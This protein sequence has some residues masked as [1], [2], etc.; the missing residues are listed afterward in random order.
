VVNVVSSITTRRMKAVDENAKYLGVLPL[1]LMEN[2]GKGVVNALK[3]E[4]DIKN[5]KITVVCGLG[6]NGGDGFVVARHLAALGAQVTVILIGS[7]ENIKTEEARTNWNALENMVFTVKRVVL[8]D[9]SEISKIKELITGSDIVVDA[10]FGTGVKG[11]IKEPF[12]TI[13]DLINE[14]NAF[15]VSVDTPS[16]LNPD[17]GEIHDK[18]VK[19]N[20][21]VTFH[22]A[23][24]GLINGAAFTGKL[25]VADIGIP[26]EAE[27]IVGPGDI[28]AAIKNRDI[29]SHKGDFGKILVISGG[30]EYHGAPVF[31]ALSALRTGADLV[32]LTVPSSVADVVRSFSPNLIVRTLPGDVLCEDA[33]GIIDP[34]INWATSIAIGPGLGLKSET[35][36]TVLTIL[37]KAR[38]KSKPLLVDADAIKI[39][40]K[41]N[42]LLKETPTLVTPHPGEF[43]ILTG[44]KLPP[45]ENIEER[46][47]IVKECAGKLGITILLKGAED[48]IS[49][50][51][52]YRV[53]LTGNPGMTVG[54]TGDV[55][56][57]IAAV[58]LAWGNSP[59]D[60][61][62]AA[63]F[64]N[65]RA[66]DIAVEK[67]G[68]HITATDVIEM[69]PHAINEIIGKPII[70]KKL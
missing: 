58:L 22:K 1:M 53:N 27:I 8:K 64:I 59:L 57:G 43:E 42:T 36:E 4:K 37:K 46:I 38:S 10:I 3:S 61:A 19:A 70:G 40:S 45:P 65:G 69:I 5:K 60:A 7:V 23:K 31:V 49:D 51:T 14:S 25:I 26:P 54:G 50:G 29:H 56:S 11:S 28:K 21:T 15:K 47:E 13:I 44:E 32:I 18:A 34:L 63:A 35:E 17:N 52:T 16:G 24:P 66:G 20:L 48:I 9:S 2:A 12:S 62:S 41:N 6:N 55:L 30:I 68:Y 39:L 67:L 33:L